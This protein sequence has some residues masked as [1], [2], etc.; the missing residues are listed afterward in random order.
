MREPF[1]LTII[2]LDPHL[3]VRASIAFGYGHSG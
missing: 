2:E 3:L 1:Q